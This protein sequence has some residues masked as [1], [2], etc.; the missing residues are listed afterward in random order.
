MIF[1]LILPGIVALCMVAGLLIAMLY[2][3]GLILKFMVLAASTIIGFI[4]G[5]ITILKLYDKMLKFA[6]IRKK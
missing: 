6:K 1:G 3:F 5:T 4:A 2:S